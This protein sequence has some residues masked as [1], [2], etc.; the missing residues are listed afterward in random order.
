MDNFNIFDIE[1]QVL[2]FMRQLDASPAPYE[3]LFIDDALHRY[4]ID[5]DRRG[6]KCG[7]Y[8]I[9]P[10]GIPAGFVQDWKRNTKANW[11]FDTS[12]MPQEQRNYYDS[13]EYKEKCELKKQQRKAELEKKHAEIADFC[14]IQIATL[15]DAPE[16]HKYLQSKQIY[17]YGVKFNGKSL[18]VPLRD[19]DGNVKSIQW[20]EPNG[21]KRFHTE[22][23]PKGSFWSVA[24]DT[25]NENSEGTILLGEGF[26]TMAKVHEL[27]GLPC[28]AGI[29]C[30][31][32]DAVAVALK[33]KYSKCKVIMTADNDLGTQIRRGFNP[34]IQQAQNLVNAGLAV[35]IAAPVFDNPED[36]TD[37][38][39]YAI[40]YGDE[41]A[42]YELLHAIERALVPKHIIALEQHIQ[43]INAQ[44][45]RRKV[46]AP[47]IWAVDGFLPA[48]LSILAGGPKVGKSIL[49]LHLSVGVAIGGCVLG[50]I[51]VQQ[52]DVLYLALE[53]TQRR[54]QERINGSDILDDTV[55]LSRLDLITN[56][57]RQHEG[58]LQY[59]QYWLETHKE[60]RLVI[61]D[62]L[63]MFRKQL[64][65]KG[66][67]YAEDYDV[68]SNIKAVGDK[69]NVPI[70]IIH[71]LKK[72]MEGDWL[73]EISGSQG[74]A[75][76][77][78]SIFSLK[79]ERNSNIGILHRTGRDVEEKD[80]FMKLENYGWILQEDAENFTMPEWKR[81]ILDFLKENISVTPMQLAI[82]ANI[83]ANTAQ[84]NL[85]RLMKE[86][87]VKKVG[88]GTYE[89][90]K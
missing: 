50:K 89:L 75:G 81:Q 88:R 71:H 3:R 11:K 15:P 36:G 20:I 1:Q 82:S 22:S 63:Q 68:I 46:F 60:A 26:A 67:M 49:A 38:D 18:A 10:D 61:I 51:F 54:L 56:I 6:S 77:A 34:G 31:F 87:I 86:G 65:G 9:H 70:L 66:N 8:C 19:I 80:F 23:A 45:L 73:S 35:G 21:D 72:G 48:G 57:P 74:I 78:D 28:V 32:F 42:R 64:T 14:R 17:P 85:Y 41:K 40:K 44:E 16:N 59:V 53:D 84:K 29:S 12:D 27:T 83:D 69:F 5:G 55:D 79:R 90:V 62:T 37:W 76:A 7:A 25:I 39:D 52:G 4:D 58:G 24:L 47:V 2:D 30:H 13:K 33:R 43:L